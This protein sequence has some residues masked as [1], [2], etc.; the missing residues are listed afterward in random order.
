[1]LPASDDTKQS[2][3]I[4]TRMSGRKASTIRTGPRLLTSNN[5]VA[6]AKSMVPRMSPS[7]PYMPALLIRTST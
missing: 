3:F 7:L 2:R 6:I 1:M 4:P 5:R